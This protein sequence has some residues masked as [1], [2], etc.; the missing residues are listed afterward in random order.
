MS[1]HTDPRGGRQ[2]LPS[3]FQK[4]S[5]MATQPRG[6]YGPRGMSR[7][8]SLRLMPD[9]RSDIEQIARQEGRAMSPTCRMLCLKGLEVYLRERAELKC[10]YSQQ[11]R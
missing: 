4:P 8:I 5:S 6:N 10:R 2:N 3:L 11:S 7:P 9:E 1:T